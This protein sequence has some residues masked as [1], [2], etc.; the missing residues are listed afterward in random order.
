MRKDHAGCTVRAQEVRKKVDVREKTK[1]RVE[2]NNLRCLTQITRMGAESLIES[3]NNS[4][5]FR[6]GVVEVIQHSL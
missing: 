2:Q 1:E 4:W 3:E 6:I 5:K